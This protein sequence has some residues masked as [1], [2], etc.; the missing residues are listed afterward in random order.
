MPGAILSAAAGRVNVMRVFGLSA[1]CGLQQAAPVTPVS[2]GKEGAEPGG[3]IID[4]PVDLH[5]KPHL[6]KSVL[7]EL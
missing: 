3:K 6:K 7:C 2:A 4:F 1:F 5:S